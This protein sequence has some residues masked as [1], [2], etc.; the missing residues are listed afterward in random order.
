MDVVTMKSVL[1]QLVRV[2]LERLWTGDGPGYDD[3][4]DNVSVHEALV[5][6]VRGGEVL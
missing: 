4:V 6:L 5:V 2:L 1:R 3:E